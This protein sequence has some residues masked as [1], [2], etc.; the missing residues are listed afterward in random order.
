MATKYGEYIRSLSFQDYGPDSYRQGTR[1]TG[2]YL[3]LDVHVEF[4]TYWSAG[5]TGKEPFQSEV[6]DFNEVM[7]W[8]GADM[9]DLS[10]LGAEVHMCLGEEK[11]THV[12]TCSTAVFVPKGLPHLPASIVRMDKRILYLQISCAGEW[13]ATPVPSDIKPSE[14][15]GWQSKYRHL[16][17]HL[18]FTRKSAW[19]YG[20]ENPDDA[21]G[22][23]TDIDCKEFGFNMSYESIKRAPYRFGPRPDKPHVH[24]AYDEF[25]LFLGMDTNDLSELGADVETGMGK[26][27]ERHPFS[28]PT[29]IKLPQGFPHSPLTVTKLYKP[30]IFAIVRP[31]G[32]VGTTTHESS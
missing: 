24:P 20:P 15:V 6:H 1:V 21:G 7:I 9:S 4:G 17:S 32:I 26:E 16:I 27:I 29:A 12:I 2:E 8:I 31:F 18:A 28:T 30:F 3:G 25:A 23:I 13:K 5:K 11:E 22:S 10:E 14:P 19:H